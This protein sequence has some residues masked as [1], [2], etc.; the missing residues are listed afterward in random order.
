MLWSEPCVRSRTGSFCGHG[1]DTTPCHVI[2]HKHFRPT[3]TTNTSLCLTTSLHAM[4]LCRNYSMVSRPIALWRA[5]GPTHISHGSLG[6]VWTVAET[7]CNLILILMSDNNY[8]S[9]AH[10][11][12]TWR[13][14]LHTTIIAP[15]TTATTTPAVSKPNGLHA[16]QVGVI[17]VSYGSMAI[18]HSVF[19]IR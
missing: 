9:P 5:I 11:W 2:C 1:T 14:S 17:R 18:F 3:S 7:N 13:D 8:I 12:W 16:V 6:Q 19:L 4:V 15:M 10:C